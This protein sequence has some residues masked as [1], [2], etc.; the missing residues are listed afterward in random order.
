MKNKVKKFFKII[1]PVLLFQLLPSAPRGD[2]SQLELYDLSE[3]LKTVIHGFLGILGVY[4]LIAIIWGAFQY[5]TAYGNEQRAQQGKTIVLYAVV[6]LTIAL[7][8]WIFVD[9]AWYIITGQKA[10][11]NLK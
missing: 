5:I 7:L 1:K 9:A 8:A 10:P 2:W 11:A 6:G 4:G 3:L